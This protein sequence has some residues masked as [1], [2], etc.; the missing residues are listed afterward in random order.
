MFTNHTLK[1]STLWVNPILFYN[2]KFVESIDGDCVSKLNYYNEYHRKQL[3]VN[4]TMWLQNRRPWQKIQP[5]TSS[6]P[7]SYRQ[8]MLLTLLYKLTS[9]LKHQQQ[10]I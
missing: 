10:N 8:R 9:Y 4:R 1:L 2:V 7:Q 3:Y 5:L 6:G